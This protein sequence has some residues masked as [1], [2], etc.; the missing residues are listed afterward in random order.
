MVTAE[1]NSSKL[2]PPFFV[3]NGRK[4]VNAKN[5]QQTLFGGSIK[6]GIHVQDTQ[7]H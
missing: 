7:Q 2:L 5:L 4:K 3:L 6:I 1:L